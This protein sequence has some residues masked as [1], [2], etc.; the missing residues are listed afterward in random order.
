VRLSSAIDDLDARVAHVLEPL[1]GRLTETAFQQPAYP[2]GRVL[3]QRLP[4]RVFLEDRRHT[5]GHRVPV[6]G[7]PPSEHL[8]K[9]AAEC[10]VVGAPVDGFAPRLL[11]THV[12]GGTKENTGRGHL[13]SEG[14]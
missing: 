10:P 12:G 9:H 3:G 11:R 8:V 4:L 2:R 13:R 5:V 1:C 6:E 7:P 14:R